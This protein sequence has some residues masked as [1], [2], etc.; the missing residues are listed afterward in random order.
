[1]VEQEHLMSEYTGVD[2]TATTT[3][4]ATDVWFVLFTLLSCPF[5]SVFRHPGF[6]RKSQNRAVD[7]I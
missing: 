7:H 3:T 6:G 4:T 5:F 1:M 2:C